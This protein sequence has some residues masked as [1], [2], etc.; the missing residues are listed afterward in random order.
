MGAISRPTILEIWSPTCT[1]CKA[2]QPDLDEVAELFSDRVDLQ[3]VSATDELETVRGLGVRA[4]P[5]LIGLRDG[6]EVLRVTGRR[7]RKDL[8]QLFEAVGDGGP[9]PEL[10]RQD[11]FVHMFAGLTLVGVGLA[12]GPVWPLVVVGTA[13]LIYGITNLFRARL[14]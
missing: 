11:V 14:G 2:M 12:I 3:M 1:E 9:V 13:V 5:T 8:H 4:T 6:R 7:S 10:N